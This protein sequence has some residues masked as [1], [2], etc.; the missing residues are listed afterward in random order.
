[1]TTAKQLRYGTGWDLYLCPSLEG[2]DQLQNQV[3]QD[4]FELDI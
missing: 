3:A 2:V 4:R 1:M